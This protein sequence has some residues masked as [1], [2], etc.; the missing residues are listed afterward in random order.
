MRLA[1]AIVTLFQWGG[2]QRDCLRISRA[3]K[4]AGHDVTIFTARRYGELPPDLDVKLLPVR[5]LSNHGRNRL[6]SEALRGA[7]ADRFDRVVG[8]DKIPGLDVLYCGES[9]YAAS[10]RGFWRKLNPRIRRMIALEASCFAPASRTHVLALAEPQVMAYR[11]AWGTPQERI[12]LLPPPIDANRRHPG[13]RTDGTR[14]RIRAA[15]GLAPDTLVLLSIG[16]FPTTK[17]FD[18]IVAVLPHFKEAKLLVCGAASHKR[19]AVALLAQARGLGVADRVFVL[20]PREDVPHVMAAV[21]LLVHPARAEASGIVIVEA[22][23]NGLP[24]IATEICGFSSHIRRAD[25]GI[26]IPE[27]FTTSALIDAL[28]RAAE[29]LARAAWSANGASYGTD[30]ELYSGIDRALEAIVKID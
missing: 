21:D 27:P 6:F 2:L 19:E 7:V 3:A 14:E 23:V 22:I 1:F 29:P 20:G 11:R 12:T 30:P 28:G 17:G 16:A 13:Y 9:C 25:A 26:V 5:P 8:F 10:K 15:L 4:Q 18:R 24:I